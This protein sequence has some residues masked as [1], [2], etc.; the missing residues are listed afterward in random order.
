MLTHIVLWKYRPEATAEQRQE[1]LSKLRDLPRAIP[2]I[3]EFSVGFDILQLERS[4][5]TGL[6]SVF[7]DRDAFDAY[8]DHPAH[9]EVAKL[10]REISAHIAS[11]DFIS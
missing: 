10:G 5:D 9:Q 6:T 8:T 2:D 4:Y 11:V 3:I 7:P 1:H